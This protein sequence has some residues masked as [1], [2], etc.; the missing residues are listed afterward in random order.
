MKK[1]GKWVSISIAVAIIIF[2]ILIDIAISSP[3]GRLLLPVEHKPQYEHPNLENFPTLLQARGNRIVNSEGNPIRLYG[4][5]PSDPARLDSQEL[6]NEEFYVHVRNTGA[7]VIRLAVHPHYW[8]DDPD[9]LWRY[10]DPVVSW[11]GENGLY[12][13]IDWHYIGNIETG[14][15]HEM[16]DISIP[17]EE[18]TSEFWRLLAS[19]FSGVPNVIFD[20]WNEPAGG[21]SATTW[22][23]YAT[24]ITR[25]IRAQG[26]NQL[27]LIGGVEF[28]RDLSWIL[29]N[30]VQDENVA[31]AV[32][33]YPAHSRVM[34]DYWF[35]DAS[36]KFPVLTSEWG[37]IDEYRDNDSSHLVGDRNSYAEPLLAYLDAHWIGWVACWYDDEW[38]PP[39]FLPDWTAPTNFGAYVIEKLQAGP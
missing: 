26:A 7:N 17:P 28:A 33:I 6:F 25:L 24:E 13:I 1:I 3:N 2:A 9:Y 4:L 39:M 30:P 10:I 8:V 22:Q 20:I 34:W 36:Q 19:Y 35:G 15:V 18:L 38:I 27:V 23:Q 21:I 16:L 29:N 12:V 31:Y 37:F 11:A 32:H 14:V 5:M